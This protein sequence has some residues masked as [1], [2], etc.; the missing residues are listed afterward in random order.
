MIFFSNPISIVLVV[1]TILA[2]ISPVIQK[3]RREQEES[4]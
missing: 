2:L 4:V 1:L 3:R